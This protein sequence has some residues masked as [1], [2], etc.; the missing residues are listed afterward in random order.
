M[1][2]SLFTV[3]AI[4]LGLAVLRAADPTPIGTQFSHAPDPPGPYPLRPATRRDKILAFLML[5]G[6]GILALVGLYFRK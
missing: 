4:T 6:A 3:C 5:V 1:L 2:T